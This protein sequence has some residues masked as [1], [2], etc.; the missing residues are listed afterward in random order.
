MNVQSQSAR[1]TPEVAEHARPTIGAISVTKPVKTK[2]VQVV[3]PHV[4]N[5]L[6]NIV[7]VA[8]QVSGVHTV[9]ITVLKTVPD[10]VGKAMDI[11]IL[12]YRGYGE[13]H[14]TNPVTLKA[15]KSCLHVQEL[16]GVLAVDAN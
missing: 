11:A 10:H 1:K 6:D 16:S 2:T 9:K 12:V 13:V 8:K 5:H 15:V 3:V 4:I 7:I 14:V